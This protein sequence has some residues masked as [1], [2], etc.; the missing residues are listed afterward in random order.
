M[1]PASE[2]MAKQL[3]EKRDF[4]KASCHQLL[5]SVTMHKDKRPSHVETSGSLVLGLY[6]HGGL[7]GITKDTKDN[8]NLAKYLLAYMRHHGM[9]DSPCQVTSLAVGRNVQAICH[10]DVRNM[11]GSLNWLLWWEASQ[12][13]L[14][15]C[16][17]NL[18]MCP[19]MQSGETSKDRVYLASS[20]TAAGMACPPSAQTPGAQRNP[21]K[22]NGAL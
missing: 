7:R 9:K 2:K 4:T 1:I 3:L 17:A 10:R 21:S 19:R 22:E 11:K 18:T 20:W 15:G 8:R 16:S 14:C 13:A 6:S 5:D 12:A